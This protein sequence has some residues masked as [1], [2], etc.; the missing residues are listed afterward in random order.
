MLR[1][2][3]RNVF[4]HKAR[5]VMTAL[6]IA[7]GVAFVC[8]TLVFGDT[9]AQALRGASA[10]SFKDVA[11]SVQA[12]SR[13]NTDDAA[14][15]ARTTALTGDLV[16]K[17]RA[18][19]GVTSVHAIVDGAAT[20]AAKDGRPLNAD[21]SWQNLAI[22]YAPDTPNTDRDSRFPLIAGRAPTAGDEMAL[23]RRTAEKAGYTIGDLVRFAVQ[24][25][26]L[27]KRLVGIVTTDDPRV[28]AGGSLALFDTGTAQQLFLQPGRFDELAVGSAPGT[29]NQELTSKVRALLPAEGIT[30]TSGA[31]L[32]DEQAQLIAESTKGLTRMLLAFAGIALFVGVFVIANT[33]TMLIAQ[34]SRETALLRAVGAS[35]R[36]VVR[37]V[38]T[39][40]GLLGLGA[41]AAGIALGIGI[42]TA[43]RPIL[44]AGG[45]DLPD[46]PLVIAT[47]ALVRSLLVGVGVTVL[48]AWLPA[49]KAAKTA[50]VE[51]LTTVDLTPPRRSL[52]LRNSLGALFTGAGVLIMLY[53]SMRRNGADSNLQAAA[54][55][56][57]LVLIGMIVS[58][59]LLSRPLIRL[60]GA[61]TTRLFGV[62]GKLAKENALRNPR[63]TAATASAL[64]IGLTLITGL[65]VT[66]SSMD[67]ALRAAAVAGLTADYKVSVSGS[68]TI[69]PALAAK[70]A[71]VPGVAESV[72]VASA[73]L[74]ARGRG[75][76]LTGADPRL[77]A[78]VCDL[79]FS[80]GSLADL[81][82]GK[83]LLSDRLAKDTGLSKG[84]TFQGRVGA[85]SNSTRELTVVGVY[86]QTRAFGGAIGT[87]D[88]VLPEA[89]VAGKL[90]S[91][92]V[93]AASERS[94]SGLDQ[95]IRKAL[96]NSPLLRVQNQDQLTKEQSGGS[97]VMLNMMYGLLGMTVVIA[98]FGVIN[99]LAMSV[100]ERTREIG[101]LRAIGLDHKGVKQ[102]VRLESV[103]ISL[104]GA[105]LGI[106][107][108]IF[109]AW[110]CGS[111]STSTLPQYEIVL[112]WARLGLFL[113]LGLAIGVLAA[114]WP[115]RRA[116]RLNMLRAINAQ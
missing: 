55:G 49:R 60:A 12:E 72:P 67:A 108:G 10:K 4:A 74:V 59:P 89:F 53:V 64:M 32:A 46:G 13:Q 17:V 39:E 20:L 102:M 1:T 58:A 34:R 71:E 110:T 25:P 114:L 62:S 84:D 19:P 113:L 88:D 48:A 14:N 68:A 50:P 109:L 65:S 83:V 16:D 69:D 29:D 3:L 90:D 116:A 47:D 112:P 57:V 5:L 9:V 81:G 76:T 18:V 103:V 80:S 96:G 6:A 75:A 100:V 86:R 70:V 77:L 37:A 31:Q 104:F 30:V 23:D 97:D 40:A 87:M 73:A 51:A 95:D 61:V 54:L 41:S 115:A 33:F 99:T 26:T 91:I 106:G 82:P 7:L 93:R 27:S 24:G 43:M 11:V 63:R 44:N 107:T 15:D 66:G 98:V 78:K 35:R 85:G 105:V 36:Q 79:R 111:L 101:L 42:A 28:T 2:A 22:N 21:S 92:L 8:G 56:S 38:L 45:A 52:V 94:T